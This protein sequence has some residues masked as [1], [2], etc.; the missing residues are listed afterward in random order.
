MTLQQTFPGVLNKPPGQ[1]EKDHGEINGFLLPSA[2][3]S[4]NHVDMCCLI[5]VNRLL[6]KPF[7]REQLL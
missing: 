4:S 6:G 3:L 1:A 2:F 5:N 7:L